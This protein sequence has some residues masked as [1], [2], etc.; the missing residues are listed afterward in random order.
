MEVLALSYFG[1][2][3]F[4]RRLINVEGNPFDRIEPTVCGQMLAISEVG[5]CC[6]SGRASRAC[7]FCQWQALFHEVVAT[8]N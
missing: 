6:D 4:L 3:T 1:V 2:F 5:L 8:L 7:H